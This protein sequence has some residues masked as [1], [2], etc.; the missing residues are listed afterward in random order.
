LHPFPAGSLTR[1]YHSFFYPAE[2]QVLP[3]FCKQADRRRPAPLLDYGVLADCQDYPGQKRIYGR[4]EKKT[5]TFRVIDRPRH[6]ILVLK[7]NPSSP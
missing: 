7:N 1:V 6:A 2:K 3:V 4:G 5:S